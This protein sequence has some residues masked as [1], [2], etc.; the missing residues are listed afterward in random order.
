MG[1]GDRFLHS[2]ADGGYVGVQGAIRRVA[3]KVGADADA[4]VTDTDPHPLEHAGRGARVVLGGEVGA[5]VTGTVSGGVVDELAEDLEQIAA[6]PLGQARAQS[7]PELPSEIIDLIR[8]LESM[9]LDQRAIRLAR[10]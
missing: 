9:Q 10:T 2:Y 5:H 1:A 4:T 8:V 7:R 6:Q 3:G